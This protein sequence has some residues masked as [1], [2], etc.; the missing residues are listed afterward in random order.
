[1]S[2]TPQPSPKGPREKPAKL[3]TALIAGV[4][5]WALLTEGLVIAR[6]GSSV[7]DMPHPQRIWVMPPAAQ[8]FVT[9]VELAAGP[10][11]AIS[12]RRD[13][14]AGMLRHKP[15]PLFSAAKLL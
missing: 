4:M 14:H 3:V 12:V 8:A 5:G 7:F 9:G 6:R 15:G 13:R 1:M 11:V 2:D 10:D